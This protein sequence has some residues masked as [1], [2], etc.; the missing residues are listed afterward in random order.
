MDE[1]GLI[2]SLDSFIEIR[3]FFL[4]YFFLSNQG[5]TLF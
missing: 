2:F 4:S 1:F 3:V 5:S